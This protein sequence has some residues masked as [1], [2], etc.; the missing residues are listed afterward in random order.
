MKRTFFA[1]PMIF[2]LLFSGQMVLGTGAGNH[3]LSR[4]L[5]KTKGALVQNG[6]YRL[7][8]K[9]KLFDILGREIS[10]LVEADLESG[11]HKIN[12]DG[13]D[14]ASGIYFYRIHTAGF[15]KTKKLMLLK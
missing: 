11:M 13:K 8:F 12:F 3:E 6:Q 2:V 1:L 9:L 10:T 5:M 15:L 7:T 4:V 14:L